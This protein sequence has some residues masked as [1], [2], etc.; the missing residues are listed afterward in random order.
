MADKYACRFI[1]LQDAPWLHPRDPK[2]PR[3][4]LTGDGVLVPVSLD[5]FYKHVAE[6][7]EVAAYLNEK[8]PKLRTMVAQVIVASDPYQEQNDGTVPALPE[9][10]EQMKAHPNEAPPPF[11][12]A[13]AERAKM[14]P[15]LRYEVIKRDGY[16]CRCCGYSVQEGA[17]LHVDHIQAVSKGGKTV[18]DNLQTLCWAC[19][20]G[21]GAK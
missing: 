4:T 7:H 17:R 10:P 13:Q 19:N 21:K 12:D 1:V 6:A 5:G 15:Q 16:R 3:G 8:H 11:I 2:V 9:E 20:L 18:D 14:T